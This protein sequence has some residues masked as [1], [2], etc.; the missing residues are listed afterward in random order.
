MV[1]IPLDQ[2]CFLFALATAIR[3]YL[4]GLNPFGSGM[5]FILY[6]GTFYARKDGVLIPL[7]QGCFLFS[8]RRER[9]CRDRGL[10]PFGSGMFF[11]LVSFIAM[12]RLLQS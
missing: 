3:T 4:D 9:W 2:G 6:P 11:I 1:L 5:F 12:K 7:D 8:G 10:N